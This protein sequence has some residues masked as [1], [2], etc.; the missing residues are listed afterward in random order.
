M[1]GPSRVSV[2]ASSIYAFYWIVFPFT[3]MI[4]PRNIRVVPNFPAGDFRG[5]CVPCKIRS[6]SWICVLTRHFPHVSHLFT[7]QQCG[8]G[9]TV[10]RTTVADGGRTATAILVY[11]GA[12]RHR[13]AETKHL[14]GQEE[15]TNTF[16]GV[17]RTR[18]FA[19]HWNG[20]GPSFCEVALLGKC[21][22]VP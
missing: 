2:Q 3:A 17:S 20:S 13:D 16:L 21:F 7:G 19:R 11:E 5:E 18:T 9:P 1:F 12:T 10:V 15:E 4:S 22:R 8:G 6:G 14:D